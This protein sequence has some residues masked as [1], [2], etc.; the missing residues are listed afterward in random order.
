MGEPG[1]ARPGDAQGQPRFA[2][3]VSSLVPS[4]A[5][6]SSLDASVRYLSIL[7]KA[8]GSD[9]ER[10]VFWGKSLKLCFKLQHVIF[11]KGKKKI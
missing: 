1:P 3:S 11:A 6:V 8:I 5:V 9:T 2:V 10:R 7:E 4:L